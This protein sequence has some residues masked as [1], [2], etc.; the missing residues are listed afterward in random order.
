MRL[1]EPYNDEWL[2]EAN[3]KKQL[4]LAAKKLKEQ[5]RHDAYQEALRVYE[6]TEGYLNEMPLKDLESLIADLEK[7][8][9]N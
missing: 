4:I 9:K 2:K 8:V 6:A 5:M 3:Y 7:I 1:P